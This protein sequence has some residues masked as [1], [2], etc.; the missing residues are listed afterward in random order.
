MFAVRR[1]PNFAVSVVLLERYD[2]AVRAEAL[3]RAARGVPL[4][5]RPHGPRRSRQHIFQ[6]HR[7]KIDRA[8]RGGGWRRPR[9]SIHA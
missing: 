4:P 9:S 8:L 3:F 6:Q 5:E 7:F 2:R 1:R